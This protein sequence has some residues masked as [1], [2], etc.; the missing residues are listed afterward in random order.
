MRTHVSR[1]SSGKYLLPLCIICSGLVWR[2]Y[3]CT[4][5]GP[6]RQSY[7]AAVSNNSCL[8]KGR[9]GYILAKG[10]VADLYP[11]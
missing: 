8:N 3:T 5:L 4:P 2:V 10:L 6:P 1:P 7:M 11:L 9:D